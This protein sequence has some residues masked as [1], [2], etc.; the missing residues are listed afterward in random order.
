[1]ANMPGR[2][3]A[4]RHPRSG[5]ACLSLRFGPLGTVTEVLLAP[6]TPTAQP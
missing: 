6:L 3:C 5:A 2:Q 1:M 4:A